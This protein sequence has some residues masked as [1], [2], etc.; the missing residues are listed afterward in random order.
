MYGGQYPQAQYR[1]HPAHQAPG[2][3]P[4]PPP[5]RS[6]LSPLAIVLIVLAG[7]FVLGTGSCILLGGL[8]LLGA[9]AEDDAANAGA[10]STAPSS[11][12]ASKGA[13]PTTP[14]STLAPTTETPAAGDSHDDGDP[15]KAKSAPSNAGTDGRTKYMCNATGWVRVCGFANVCSNQLVSGMGVGYDR[16]SASMMAKNACEN[17]ARIKGGGGV[18]TVACS[19]AK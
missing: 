17:M 12:V 10:T 5:P 9:Q 13:V 6:G 19:V 1:P 18:C 16:M 11:N 4:P 8:V 3:P 15:A 7:V 2:F 14:P